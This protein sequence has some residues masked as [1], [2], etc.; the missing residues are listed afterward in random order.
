[1][2]GTVCVLPSGRVAVGRSDGIIDI[3]GSQS[4]CLLGQ[5]H[6]HSGEVEALDVLPNGRLVSGGRDSII[7][8]WHVGRRALS[9]ELQGHEGIV[10]MLSIRRDGTLASSAT[11]GT[12]RVWD[13]DQRRER[14]V[15]D[16]PD[17]D[18]YGMSWMWGDHIASG[19]EMSGWLQW[20]TATGQ[21]IGKYVSLDE[22]VYAA[23]VLPQGWTAL[24]HFGVVQLFNSK[25]QYLAKPLYYHNHFVTT[26]RAV[27]NRA[28]VS[29]SLRI[30]KKQRYREVIV[31]DL[32]KRQGL[33]FNIGKLKPH[34]IGVLADGTVVAANHDGELIWRDRR[35][36]AV[37]ERQERWLEFDD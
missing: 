24:S 12:V 4:R 25:R 7:R 34:G 14:V 8:I 13:L 20:D 1:M 6:G 37:V 9:M 23:A 26:L 19:S 33:Q 35:E 5:L 30:E 2:T 15:L 16:R 31:W 10:A 22:R 27:S 3:W 28:I 32:F 29:T 21:R 17:G 11:D 18:V 36:G